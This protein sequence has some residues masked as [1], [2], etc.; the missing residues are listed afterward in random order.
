VT[1]DEALDPRNAYAVSKVA[2]E[3][4]AASWAHKT[5]PSFRFTAKLW[6]RFTHDRGTAWTDAEVKEAR[7]AFDV[8]QEAVETGDTQDPDLDVTRTA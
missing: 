7:A 6:R 5:P 1:E 2:Q 3:H 4:Y 8:L